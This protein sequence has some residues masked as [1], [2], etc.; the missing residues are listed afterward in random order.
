MAEYGCPASEPLGPILI[1]WVLLATFH[2][3]AV[4]KNHMTVALRLYTGL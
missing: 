1:E 4:L 3:T 2:F